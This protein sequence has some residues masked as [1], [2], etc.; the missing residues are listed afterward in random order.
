MRMASY[1][2]DTEMILV[3][4]KARQVRE[5]IGMEVSTVQWEE[6]GGTTVHFKVMAILIP[7]I[8]SDQNDRI[9]L[10]HGTVA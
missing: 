2:T 3:E 6:K 4:M 8:R 9:G 1:L 10:V 5:I 7:N